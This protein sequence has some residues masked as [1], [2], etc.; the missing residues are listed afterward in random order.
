MGFSQYRLVLATVFS[1]QTSGSAY[2]GLFQD[3]RVFVTVFSEQTAGS[4]YVG[5]FQDR[6]VFVG[7]LLGR[8]TGSDLIFLNA[9]GH[10]LRIFQ[11]RWITTEVFSQQ[12]DSV[13]DFLK[14]DRE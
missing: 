13:W 3:R 5:L 8:Y 10:C 12:T 7:L 9:D 2:I 14:T 6:R 11:S 1:R 4:G